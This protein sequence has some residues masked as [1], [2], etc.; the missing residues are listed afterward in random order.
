MY[1]QGR[2]QLN[3]ASHISLKLLFLRGE[4]TNNPSSPP[5]SPQ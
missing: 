3:T 5:P 2:K 4:K 1:K